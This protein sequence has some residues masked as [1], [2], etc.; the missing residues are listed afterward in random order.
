MTNTRISWWKYFLPKTIKG[1]I[2]AFL[3]LTVLTLEI[4]FSSCL[5]YIFL[6]TETQLI[7]STMDST[8]TEIVNKD[9]AHGRPPR[10]DRFSQLY[11]SGNPTH[12]I[13]AYFGELPDGY[14][15]YTSGEDLYI[16]VKTINGKKYVLTRSQHEFEQWERNIFLNGLL[17]LFVITLISF[18]LCLW[19]ARRSFRPVSRLLDE[20]RQ[21]NQEIQ[22]GRLGSDSF[23]G[24]W[25]KNEIGELAKSFQIITSRLYQLLMSERQFASE[26]SHELRTPLTVMSTSMELLKNSKNLN[27]HEQRII[28]RAHRTT[29]RMTEIVNIFLNLARQDYE[30]SEKIAEIIDIVEENEP[31]WRSEAKAKG[32]QL[33]IKYDEDANHKKFNTIL[34][35]LVFNNL[36]FNAIKY[37]QKG[38]IKITLDKDSFSV[39]DTGSGISIKEREHIFDKGFRGKSGIAEG[40]MGYGL[41]L[42]IA[43]RI[44]NVL[45]WR[46]TME[47]SE[48]NGTIFTVI[49]D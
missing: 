10:L 1:R 5:I 33:F 41:G 23:S 9:L 16:F 24:I 29:L 12:E 45:G 28:Q 30:H 42:S 34:A 8:I 20:T 35:A 18:G 37:T 11:I 17:L 15:E 27:D 48:N 7:S 26:V 44:C 25:E 39:L 49:F 21:L 13:P 31:V 2:V 6:E 22:E 40:I 14:S 43:S 19:M 4:I 32:L 47:S 3:T 46:I 36:V 38:H